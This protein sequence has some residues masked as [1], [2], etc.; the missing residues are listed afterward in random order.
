MESSANSRDWSIR[1]R[2]RSGTFID[3]ERN[4]NNK[5]LKGKVEKTDK[6]INIFQIIEMNRM[7]QRSAVL[8]LR[9]KGL[10]KKAI[11][12]ELVAVLQEN[13]VSCSSVTRF[14]SGGKLCW[15]RIRKR[16]HDRLKTMASMK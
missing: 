1:Y 15:V 16:P 3:N 11:H 9:L 14:L 12:H 2:S 10:S 5:F 7:Q 6:N 8:F 4:S 13:A